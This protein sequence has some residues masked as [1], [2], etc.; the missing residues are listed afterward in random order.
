MG[1][2]KRLAMVALALGGTVP[3]A[4]QMP[5]QSADRATPS[6]SNAATARARAIVLR[7]LSVS[8][9]QSMQSKVSVTLLTT[10]HIR[11]AAASESS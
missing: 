2:S 4:A 5:S 9:G 10:S 3:L 11:L 8:L 6:S 7:A 1:R